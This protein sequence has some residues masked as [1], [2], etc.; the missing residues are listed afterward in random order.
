MAV[1]NG[2]RVLEYAC[3][4]VHDGKNVVYDLRHSNPNLGTDEKTDA[5]IGGAN[6]AMYY[7]AAIA[8]K[9]AQTSDDI[10]LR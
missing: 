2:K 9:V 4:K 10:F 5:Y 3:K 6:W 8:V 1:M 7:V